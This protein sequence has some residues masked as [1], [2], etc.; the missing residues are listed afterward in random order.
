MIE[1]KNNA[2]IGIL[3][4]YITFRYTNSLNPNLNLNDWN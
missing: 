4:Y 1:I 2:E 3:F